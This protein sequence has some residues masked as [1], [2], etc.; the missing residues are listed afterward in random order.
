MRWKQIIQNHKFS[1]LKESEF[2]MIK[3]SAK[4][5]MRIRV[6]SVTESNSLLKHT[7]DCPRKI[8]GEYFAGTSSK[9]KL[10]FSWFPRLWRVWTLKFEYWQLKLKAS[11][12]RC[13]GILIQPKSSKRPTLEGQL[14]DF[15]SSIVENLQISN[16][17]NCNCDLW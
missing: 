14:Y 2:K 6:N 16:F 15:E 12:P 11:R 3:K 10:T 13:F 17:V 1:N 8:L 4:T 5:L 7:C 9:S